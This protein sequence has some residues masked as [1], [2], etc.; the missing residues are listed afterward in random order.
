MT[1]A[2]P[3]SVPTVE[4]L[5][6]ERYEPIAIVGVGLRFPGG[7]NSVED[8]D[9]FLREGRSGIVDLPGGRWDVAAF[10]PRE[11]GERGKIQTTGGGFLDRIDQFD[12]GFFNISP[13]EAQYIDPQQRMLL[14]TA[15]QAL[16]HA[17]IDPAPLR[18][19]NGGVYV[20]ASSID[21]ALEISELPY[22]DL[23]GH[24]ASGITM[25]P[26]SGRLSYF[27]G[28]RGPSVSVDTA[29]SSSLTALH[30]AVQALRA[31]ECDLALC[32]GVNALHH[33][34]IPVIFSHGQM[35]APDGLCKTFDES[36][37]GYVR[38]EGCGV[39]VL[40]RL[41][42][43]HADGDRVLA[44][45]RGTAV[46]Q[47]GDSAG[48]TVPNGAAQ[49]VVI[50]N[51][52]AAA[53]LTPADIQYVE[54]HGTGTP[55]GDPIELGAINDVFAESHRDGNP[56]LVGSVKTNLGHME[57]ASGIVGLIKTM[58]QLRS[59]TI[60]PHLNLRTPSRRIPWASYPVEVPTECRPWPASTRRA[61]VNSFGFAGTIAAVV[62]EQ[63]PPEPAPA[64]TGPDLRPAGHVFTLSA[65]GAVALRAQAEAYR[66]HLA[67]RADVDLDR[68][69]Y[70]GNVGRTHH[71]HRRA[72]IVADPG[73]LDALLAAIA[74]DEDPPAPAGIRKVAFM[75]SGQGS[76]YAGMGADLYH[77]FPVFRRCVDECDDL[78]AAPLGRSVRALLLG[79]LTDPTEIDQTWLTQPALFTLELALARLWTSWGIR[80]NV[81]LGHS[82]GEVVAATVAGLFTVEDAV[83]LVSARGRLMQS[84]T[85][86][87]GMAAV[88]ADVE[89]VEPMLASRVQ[90][91][92]AAVNSPGQCVVSG[93]SAELDSFLADLR[94]QGIR[95]D[96]LTVSHA[97]HSPLMAEVF[98]EFRAALAGITFHE[99][100]VT[101][102]SN[103]T[104][105][106]ARY[107]EVA[108]PE[109]WVRHIGEPVRFLAGVRAIARRGRHAIIELGP[110]GTLTA[111]ARQCV[112]ADSQRWF[113]SLSRRERTA[114]VTLRSLADLYTA[115]LPVSWTGVHQDRPKHT[116]DL[117]T[118]RFQRRRYWLPAASGQAEAATATAPGEHPLLGR[119]VP[120]AQ[121]REFTARYRATGPAPLGDHVVDGTVVVPLSA[122]VELLLAVQDEVFGQHGGALREVT[123]HAPLTL[124][125]EPTVVRTRLTPR[126]DD[127]VEV[128]V[129]SGGGADETLHASAVVTESA[130]PAG[131]AGDPGTPDGVVDDERDGDTGYLDLASVGRTP[132]PRLRLL[133]RAVRH[134]EVITG[135]LTNRQ[136]LPGEHLPVD[137]LECALQAISVLHPAGPGQLP[138][139]AGSVRLFRRPRGERVLV[140]ARLRPPTDTDPTGQAD[141][142][143]LDG[144]RPVAELLG[145][146]LAATDPARPR[147]FTHRVDWLR[148]SRIAVAGP[149]RH[150]VLAHADPDTRAALTGLDPAAG[151]TVTPVPGPDEL[152]AALGDP[153]VTDVAWFWRGGAGPMSAGRLTAESEENYRDLLRTVAAVDRA[154]AERPPRIWLVTQGAQT[155][156]G[157]AS[158]T[159]GTLCAASVWGFGPVLLTEYPQYRATMVDL[160]GPAD[161]AALV[162]EWRASRPDEVQLA[163]RAGRRYAR[164]LLPGEHTPPW[165]G[166][167][168]VGTRDDGQVE[169]APAPVTPP[170]AGELRV[171]LDRVAPLPDG[172]VVGAG[173][174]RQ[175]GAEGGFT[176]GGTVVVAYRGAVARSVTL[177]VAGALALPDP[178]RSTAAVA[179][180]AAAL[181]DGTDLAALPDAARMAI[182]L[183]DCTGLPEITQ[184][185][186]D[187]AAEALRVAGREPQ[188]GRVLL[189]LEPGPTDAAP[190]TDGGAG[191]RIRPDRT[192]VVTGGLGGLG[193]VTARKLVDLGA[194]HLTLV[195]RSGRA[196]P[197]AA[198]VLTELRKRA[199]VLL[200]AAD[201]GRPGDV[202]RLTDQ[203]R[204]LDRPVGGFVHAAGAIGKELI[205][206]LDWPAVDE[207]F[208]P[209]VYGGWLLHEASRRFPEHEFFVVYS[210]VAA[211]VG[212]A[213]QAHYAAASAFL[214]A[215]AVWRA[216]QGLPALSINWGAWAQVGMSARLDEQF[217]REID[218]SGIR[219]FSPARAL[220]TLTELWQR[221]VAHRV[222]GEYDWARIAGANP[223]GNALY[224][225]VVDPD[226]GAGEGSDLHGRLLR[227]E[228]D[229]AALIG[230]LV[231]EQVARALHLDSAADLDQS[232]EFVALGLDSLMAVELKTGLERE[233]R[234]ALPASLTF[235]HPSPRQ[236]VEFLDRRFAA[237]HVR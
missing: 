20:G 80:P 127:A 31:G 27:L 54:A 122:V 228:A 26:L 4:E 9:V 129:S 210:S 98:D 109:Y 140:R 63:A 70:T 236:L 165:P 131:P 225:R 102:V 173:T 40:K 62:L 17:N 215:L 196:T 209:K 60:Y 44:V 66:Q 201:V 105:A 48:L 89:Q 138:T 133:T 192:Y 185:P 35:L 132:G 187:E 38:A 147:S 232:V 85:A 151:I 53:R 181:A 124:T 12:A 159:G 46:G 1:D 168:T 233:L 149:A 37:D 8:F 76:Q 195:S 45:I 167:F 121:P 216:A 23:D 15:W 24:L 67:E 81:L 163:F 157:D 50:R 223:S 186:L 41:S 221:P 87:G 142:L 55:L 146:R 115:G 145:V 235:D 154:G 2:A 110:S 77:R 74:A 14:E 71:S 118:Y 65:K 152:A 79:D 91:A 189:R 21:Y 213:T 164:R 120:G 220:A 7:C 219:F 237:E 99:P 72:G 143:L 59:A 56:L 25:F 29:C 116:V 207:Q 203:L 100:T 214:D 123:L 174:V 88:H 94:G 205:A 93:A 126:G 128:R 32:G 208:G 68:L 51:A 161:L 178:A 211:I 166:G 229:R 97:F 150:V 104:G 170:A 137:V 191:A 224:S 139:A 190:S 200:V 19:G 5:L 206:K 34:R 204:A 222:V 202:D 107:A 13:K 218:R 108:D 39:V 114:E 10:T 69:C 226:A 153:T 64:S 101:L 194:R 83:T 36:A 175:V 11:P 169:L 33:P 136:A 112:P 197:E 84:V 90:L 176:P 172:R 199:E 231:R 148:E 47:D 193:L 230:A 16:E 119:E 182:A 78:F 22:A 30:L 96:R 103:L 162:D 82:I 234:L 180:A 28:W 217:V 135:A 171:R 177:P 6:A 141:V 75:F 160:G 155:L 212:G 52:L 95:V 57:P 42:R 130:E 158:G 43:A 227:P 113:V 188:P 106:V 3:R 144:D 198:A 111:Q 61:V 183:A 125:D 184:Y 156:P 49:E 117:P 73:Q 134:G 86:P 92:V 18:R 179:V 58:L